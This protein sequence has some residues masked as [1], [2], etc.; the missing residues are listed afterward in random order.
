MVVLVVVAWL[1]VLQLGNDG[2]V[3]GIGR[4]NIF[5]Q[6]NNGEVGGGGGME[7][8]RVFGG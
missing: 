5:R 7:N 8:E 1:R 3:I 4:A 2:C 6:Q